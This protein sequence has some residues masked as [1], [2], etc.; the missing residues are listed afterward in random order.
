MVRVHMILTNANVPY[1]TWV[2]SAIQF[3]VQSAAHRRRVTA[4]TPAMLSV[5]PIGTMIAAC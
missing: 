2:P 4:A 3:S 1:L 5:A